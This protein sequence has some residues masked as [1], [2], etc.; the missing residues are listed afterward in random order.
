MTA[1]SQ[2]CGTCRWGRFPM[3]RQAKPKIRKGSYGWCEWPD[4]SERL[5]FSITGHFLFRAPVI[6]RCEITPEETNCPC[7]A[8]KEKE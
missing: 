5:P 3:T 2:T 7:W 6:P 4:P 8:A 1:Q